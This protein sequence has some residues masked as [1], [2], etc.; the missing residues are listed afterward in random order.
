ARS[1]L[2]LVHG[3]LQGV[4][5]GLEFALPL[6]DNFKLKLETMKLNRCVVDASSHLCGL[7]L[8]LTQRALQVALNSLQFIRRVSL[9]EKFLRRCI[10]GSLNCLCQLDRGSLQKLEGGAVILRDYQRA[11]A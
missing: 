8:T 7:R 11:I 1:S 3:P 9:K 2:S 10:S 6:L 5:F 4:Q